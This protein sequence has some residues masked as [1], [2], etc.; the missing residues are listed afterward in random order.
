MKTEETAVVVAETTEVA[1]VDPQAMVAAATNQ[2]KVLANVISSQG[3]FSNI[4]GRKY[5][6]VEGWT[7]LARMNG[8]IAQEVE[9][10]ER[11]DGSFAA[12]VHLVRVEDQ[13]VVGRASAEC[14][15]PGEPMWQKRPP[16]ARRSMA[17]TRATGKACRLAYS[18]IMA[19]SGFEAT[20]F[21]EMPAEVDSELPRP[22]AHQTVL[23]PEVTRG[24]NGQKGTVD[25]RKKVMFAKACEFFEKNPDRGEGKSPAEMAGNFI[26]GAIDKKY[27]QIRSHEDIDAV[28]RAFASMEDTL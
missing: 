22:K 3:L 17:A 28:G 7:T 16:Y 27:K 13:K 11:E 10:I 2:A 23:N 24:G 8:V 25:H 12:I 14:G 9:N 19:L 26:E 6:R 4:Q 5:V 1:P 18:W 21:E 20:P 15:G